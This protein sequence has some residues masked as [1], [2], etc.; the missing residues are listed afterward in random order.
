LGFLLFSLLIILNILVS[1]GVA[2]NVLLAQEGS[3]VVENQHLDRAGNIFVPIVVAGRIFSGNDN[4]PLPPDSYIDDGSNPPVV[5]TDPAATACASF[6]DITNFSDETIYIFWVASNNEEILYKI[7]GSGRHYWQHTYQFNEWRIRDDAANLIDTH[8]VQGCTN[9]AKN[10]FIDDLPPC[11]GILNIALQNLATEELISGF[12]PLRDGMIVDLSQLPP[13]VIYIKA[14]D[15]VESIEVLGGGAVIALNELPYQYPH[16]GVAWEPSAGI[17]TLIFNAYRKDDAVG[18]VCDRSELTLVVRNDATPIPTETITATVTASP[19]PTLGGT[20]SA[21]PVLPTTTPSATPTKSVTALPPTMTPTSTSTSTATATPLPTCSGRIESLHLYDLAAE[22]PIPGYTPLVN[23]MVIPLNELPEQFNID[24]T[25]GNGIKSLLFNVNGVESLE[26]AAPYRYPG[27]N[28][29]PWEPAP[30][31]YTIRATAYELADAQGARCDEETVTVHVVQANQT[32]TP[33]PTQSPTVT[34]TPT[35]MPTVTPVATPQG[36]CIGNWSWR[37]LNEDGLQSANEPGLAGI[38][39][40]LWVDN[41]HNGLPDRIVDTTTS[42]EDGIY[43]FCGLDSTLSYIVEFGSLPQ[44][45]FTLND[46]GD[47]EAL[48]SDADPIRGLTA[49]IQLTAGQ[50][51]DTIDAG[52]VCGELN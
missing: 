5:A 44:C 22:Q 9:T 4:R 37:D 35:I 42:D 30:G 7:L 47:N 27:S 8:L 12:N 40:Y 2:G 16:N 11:G 18:K 24:A 41:D 25:L 43:A 3:Q 23:G 31:T 39:L 33:T 50:N 45:R 52:Y 48:D 26:N 46:Q 19:S 34:A 20:P 38:D 1:G 29:Y 13:A 49:P 15:A 51:N 14:Q 28:I 17:Y 6:I 36:S 10:I 21:T 32:V